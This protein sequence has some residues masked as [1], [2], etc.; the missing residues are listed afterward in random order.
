MDPLSSPHT[1]KPLL[2]LD[3]LWQNILDQSMRRIYIF[4]RLFGVDN[5]MML[6]FLNL[7]FFS[8]DSLAVHNGHE[9]S[10]KDKDNDPRSDVN[11]AVAYHGAWWYNRC[12]ASNLNGKYLSGNHT[13]YADGV[14][15]KA[16]K[17]HYYSY[18]TTQMKIRRKHD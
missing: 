5:K 17:G 6:L 10:T 13:S 2:E 11:C 15:W 14:N 16:W 18:K 4:G 1:N 12:H 9:F 7:S 8:G 3:P